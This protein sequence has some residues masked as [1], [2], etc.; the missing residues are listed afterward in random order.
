MDRGENLKV[1][2]DHYQGKPKEWFVVWAKNEREAFL[3][4]DPIVAEPDMDSL[5]EL[6][7]PGF[8]DFTVKYDKEDKVVSFFP[9][10]EDVEG[11]YWLVLG[12]ALGQGDNVD[13]YVL[14]IVRKKGKMRRK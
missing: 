5:M 7:A 11:D 4:I 6:H 12:G 1:W 3:Q 13:E 8:V 2:I 10:K 9:P 14:E